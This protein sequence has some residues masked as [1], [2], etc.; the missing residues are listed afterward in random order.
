MSADL[1][2][3]LLRAYAAADLAPDERAAAVAKVHALPAGVFALA[4]ALATGPTL[5]E[6]LAALARVLDVV[7]EVAGGGAA[8]PPAASLA[9]GARRP[10][11]GVSY[12]AAQLRA[13]HSTLLLIEPN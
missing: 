4:E 6:Q 9:V 12:S 2:E 11:V 13:V 7:L 5:A 1:R 10:F 8:S 3:R